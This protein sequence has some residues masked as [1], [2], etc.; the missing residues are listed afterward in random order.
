MTEVKANIITETFN[1]LWDFFCF[2][3]LSILNIKQVYPVKHI[4]LGISNNYII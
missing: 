3:Y 4:E 2:R 1:N